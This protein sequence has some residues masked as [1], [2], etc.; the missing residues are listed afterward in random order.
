MSEEE[1]ESESE[2]ESDSSSSPEGSLS[3]DAMA[4]N[5]L[6][7]RRKDEQRLQLDLSKHQQLLVDSQKMNESLK[8]CLGWTE[9]LISEG[10][11]ALA[12]RVRVSDVALGGRVLVEDD[13]EEVDENEGMSD[14]GGRFLKEAREKAAAGKNAGGGSPWMPAK[15]D[16]DS[17][18]EVDEEGM[19]LS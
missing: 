1:S 5:D 13:A 15:E 19:R 10:R 3:P 16:R 8:R 7:H 11:K 6:R 2:I 14:I 18:V 17:G 12:Y 4:E 9:E